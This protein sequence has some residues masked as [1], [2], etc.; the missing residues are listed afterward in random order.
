MNSPPPT[1]S[2]SFFGLDAHFSM[3]ALL[4]GVVPMLALLTVMCGSFADALQM[5]IISTICTLGI[6]GFFWA[7]VAMS[8]GA[9]LQVLVPSLRVKP[10][11]GAAPGAAPSR[12]EPPGAGA[13]KSVS[14]LLVKYASG[15]LSQGASEEGVRRDLLWSG[16]SEVQATAALEEA[17]ALLTAAPV[18][19]SGRAGDAG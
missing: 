5:I 19:N 16:W 17:R 10:G 1:G 3:R 4:I 12:L 8:F 7:G 15:K 6:G 18:A 13:E 2:R 9:V 11:V 14:H